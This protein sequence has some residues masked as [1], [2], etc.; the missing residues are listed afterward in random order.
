MKS[1][2]KDLRCYSPAQKKFLRRLLAAIPAYYR[3]R[4]AALAIFGSYARHENRKNSDL[5][6]LIVVDSFPFKGRRKRQEEFIRRVEFPLAGPMAVCEREG[7]RTDLSTLILTPQEARAFNPLYLDMVVDHILLYDREGLMKGIFSAVRAKMK[8]WGSRKR[9]LA[10][11]WYWSIKP[12]T[13]WG[14][15]IDYDQ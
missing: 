14:E 15:V 2:D 12:G 7:I 11:H 1:R 8:R 9:F 6:L 4:L 3:H 10:G 5:D 13:K